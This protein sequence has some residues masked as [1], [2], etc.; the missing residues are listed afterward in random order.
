M[1]G[2]ATQ[3]HKNAKARVRDI[4]PMAQRTQGLPGPA[5]RIPI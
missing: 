3:M 2:L 1:M 5:S 4:Y